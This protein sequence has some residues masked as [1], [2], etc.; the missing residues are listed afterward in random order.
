MANIAYT[1]VV[2]SRELEGNTSGDGTLEHDIL[3]SEREAKL[4]INGTERTLFIGHLNPLRNTKDG[5][6]SGVQGR[7][8]N[9]GYAPGPADGK[10]GPRTKAA[11]EAFQEDHKLTVNGQMSDAL[12]AKVEEVYGS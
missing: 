11:I 3:A 5:G 12:I 4:K 10:L 2:G 7:L 6:V 9:L 8:R 1:L